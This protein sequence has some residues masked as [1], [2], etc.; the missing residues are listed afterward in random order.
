MAKLKKVGKVAKT[1]S[2]EEIHARIW[3]LDMK[4]FGKMGVD[5]FLILQEKANSEDRKHLD[6][7]MKRLELETTVRRIVREELAKLQPAPARA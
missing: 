6:G 7:I 5:E 3:S 2:P 1:S 4:S